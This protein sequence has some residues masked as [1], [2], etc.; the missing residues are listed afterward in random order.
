MIR[1]GQ[2][3]GD[4]V[5]AARAR[6]V[7]AGIPEREAALDAIV[8]AMQVLQCDRASLLTRDRDPIP[9]RFQ[10]DLEPLLRRR[11]A[12]EPIA[13]IRGFQ[14][15]WGRDFTVSPAVLIP[16]PETELIIE[17]ALAWRRT[18]S[19]RNSA[20]LIVDVG[21]GSGCLAITLAC[22]WPDARVVATDVSDAALAVARHNAQRYDVEQRIHFV[23]QP[24][25]ADV[26]GP[27]DLVVA[28]P[29][30][31][32]DAELSSLPPEVR[33]YEPHTALFGGADGLR[34]AHAIVHITSTRLARDGRLLMEIG[35]GQADA[36]RVAV[37]GTPGL[38]LLDVRADL[39]GIPRVVVIASE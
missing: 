17:C 2:V 36:V 29:P 26:E 16:R 3:L 31:V 11:E 21:T 32:T 18:G 33:D 37:H 7:H 23:A 28:N 19:M 5:R 12:R 34:E 10:D 9:P 1:S 13:Y 6:L 15:F 38:S 22:E 20:P 4:A 24:Y 25:L 30:Y 39:Q 35:A 8:L 14:E 27:I